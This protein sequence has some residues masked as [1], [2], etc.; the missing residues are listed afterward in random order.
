MQKQSD[1][2][3]KICRVGNQKSVGL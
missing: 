3:S 2:K 1:W